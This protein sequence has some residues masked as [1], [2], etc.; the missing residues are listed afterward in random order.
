PVV[1]NPL[2]PR[3]IDEQAKRNTF[4]YVNHRR[5]RSNDVCPKI[6]VDQPHQCDISLGEVG[7][8]YVA[9]KQSLVE[10]RGKECAVEIQVRLLYTVKMHLYTG[11][12]KG[13]PKKPKHGREFRR[14]PHVTE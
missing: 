2:G 12:Y 6:R 1:E 8:E 7:R 13:N 14:V 4:A 3:H 11:K 9:K 5:D 10:E